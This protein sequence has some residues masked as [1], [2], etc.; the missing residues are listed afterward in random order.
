[1]RSCGRRARRTGRDT[2]LIRC[3]I[4]SG[5][6]WA[7]RQPARPR[8]RS[9]WTRRRC[10][11][12]WRSSR[13]RW[14]RAGGGRGGAVRRLVPGR[15]PPFG[16]A[17]VRALGRDGARGVAS[18]IRGC[19][20]AGGDGRGCARRC[21]R[22]GR[23]VAPASG[24]RAVQLARG[25]GAHA[26][27]CAGG[28]PRRCARGRARA[29]VAPGGRAGRRARPGG[30]QPRHGAAAGAAGPAVVAVQAEK[31]EQVERETSPDARDRSATPQPERA[32]RPIRDRI[33]METRPSERARPASRSRR[34]FIAAAGTVIA[35]SAGLG[36]WLALQGAFPDRTA[37]P[38]C[39][40]RMSP[41]RTGSSLS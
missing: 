26:G 12:T 23:V 5:R 4:S 33:P 1:M 28:R 34:R 3:S 7:T 8:T 18:P 20:G 30:R 35:I 15:L 2:R 19:S 11:A 16:C 10:R 14:W 24:G 29:R 37:S 27:A 22:G 6:S 32:I 38:C 41:G 9:C 17:G 40:L 36:S 31:G 21:E 13:W 25:A 39:R